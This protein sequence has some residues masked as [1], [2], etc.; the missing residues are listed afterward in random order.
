MMTNDDSA[1]LLSSLFTKERRETP[2][3]VFGS[4]AR[5]AYMLMMVEPV[6]QRS[7]RG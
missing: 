7:E 2:R 1:T 5:M 4:L 3:R 6:G